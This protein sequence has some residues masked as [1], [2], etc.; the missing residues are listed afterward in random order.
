MGD[1]LKIIKIIRHEYFWL[2]VIVLL[3]YLLRILPYLLGYPIPFGEE[4]M[5]DFE[6][7]QYLVD[8]QQINWSGSFYDYGVFPVLHLFVY[9]LTLLGLQPLTAFLFIP[10]LLP[11]VGLIFFY[12]FLRQFADKRISLLA[13]LVVATFGPHIYWSSQPMRETVSLF[14]FPLVMYL[15]DRVIRQWPAR[16]L[17]HLLFV[18]SLIVIIFVH[19]WL[20]VVLAGWLIFYAALFAPNR[21]AL[22]YTLVVAGGFTGLTAGYWQLVFSRAFTLLKIF[23]GHSIAGMASGAI[24]LGV[25]F[26][27]RRY[28]HNISRWLQKRF[29]QGILIAFAIGF[30][31]LVALFAVPLQYPPQIWTGFGLLFFLLI[32]GLLVQQH[33]QL[34]RLS[35][36]T[37]FFG[38]LWLAAL[39]LIVATHQT[40]NRLPFDPF[41]TLEFA[42]FPLSGVVAIG[43][44]WLTR[45]RLWAV[46]LVSALMIGLATFTYP[47]KLI[48]QTNF[49]QTPFYDLRSDIRYIS[50]A[51]RELIA[52]ANEHGYQVYSPVTEINTYQNVFFPAQKQR[53]VLVT[54]Y[55]KTIQD[56]YDK[57]NDP[58]VGV[59]KLTQ[60]PDALI[61]AA[62]IYQNTEGRLYVWDGNQD[63]F[64]GVNEIHLTNDGKIDSAYCLGHTIPPTMVSG[65][66]YAVAI[67]I[68]N[69]GEVTW[70]A[71]DK[72]RLGSDLPANNK[73]WGR[74]TSRI[75]L[76]AAQLIEPRQTITFSFTLTAPTE[77]DVY[78][79]YWRMLREKVY[80]FGNRCGQPE[81][82]VTE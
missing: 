14:F 48:Y 9:L 79:A 65:Q 49:A 40:I 38:L 16:W 64:S 56:H 21:P 60:L 50:P 15:A 82:T 41:R 10:Q 67:T 76:P 45:Q 70:S 29:G 33:E 37:I 13:C 23:V 71:Q 35:L 58:V 24:G 63:I 28:H 57:I 27:L 5:R 55:D 1:R 66:T 54:K 77:P 53:V 4:G 22:T 6:Q 36:T 11:S 59:L 8:N 43:I 39:Y 75:Y 73:R 2:A 80:W 25:V 20:P 78:P 46:G 7:V 42:I 72:Y 18:G 74:L 3:T 26:S 47:S 19:S 31:A 81:I 52:W 69:V 12:H 17:D 32:V 44:N 30:V 51:I 62:P 34:L 61:Q 68:Q